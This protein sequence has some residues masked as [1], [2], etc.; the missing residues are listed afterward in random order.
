[1]RAGAAV[2]GIPALA[3]AATVDGTGEAEAMHAFLAGLTAS[4]PTATAAMDSTGDAHAGPV[5][6]AGVP[7]PAAAAGTAR[8]AAGL[9]ASAATCPASGGFLLRRP[10]VAL[11]KVSFESCCMQACFIRL[12]AHHL[13]DHQSVLVCSFN[14]C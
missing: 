9:A 5:A 10:V 14:G 1:V 2:A 12:Q 13:H 11:P 6:A 8:A 3:W 4:A 7:S